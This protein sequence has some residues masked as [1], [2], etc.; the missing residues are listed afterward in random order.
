MRQ[1]ID[2]SFGPEYLDA[3]NKWGIVD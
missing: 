2:K 1:A 3:I